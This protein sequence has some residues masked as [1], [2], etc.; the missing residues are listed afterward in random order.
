MK[1]EDVPAELVETGG[2]ILH[3]R[4]G[5]ASTIT[6]AEYKAAVA[7]VLAAVLP[8]AEHAPAPAGVLTADDLDAL[9]A[10]AHVVDA[11]GDLWEKR[12]GWWP[13]DDAPG[14]AAASIARFAPELRP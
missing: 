6:F 9:P 7:E 1:P 11:D 8:L 13:L 2:E 12:T 3:S 4:F 10:G 5:W 14:L